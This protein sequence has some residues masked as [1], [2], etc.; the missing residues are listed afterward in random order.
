MDSHGNH[1][2]LEEIPIVGIGHGVT[3]CLF[4]PLLVCFDHDLIKRI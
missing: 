2:Q 1:N 4:E 3:Q